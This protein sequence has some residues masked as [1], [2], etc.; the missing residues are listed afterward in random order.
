LP[1]HRD[2]D[3]QIHQGRAELLRDIDR[4]QLRYARFH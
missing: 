4:R 1:E 2:R 3:C